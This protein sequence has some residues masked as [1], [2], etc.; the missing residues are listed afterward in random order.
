[1][2]RECQ[3]SDH[4]SHHTNPTPPHIELSYLHF[5]P[6]HNN[7]TLWCLVWVGRI[8]HPIHTHSLQL[9]CDLDMFQL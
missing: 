4:V 1:M 3:L 7:T 8:P 9:H 6:D 5:L 2:L